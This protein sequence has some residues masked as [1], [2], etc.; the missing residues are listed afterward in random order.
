MFAPQIVI[1]SASAQ[2]RAGERIG[3]R[4]ISLDHANVFRSIDKDAVPGEQLVDL[5][6]LRDEFIQK[7]IETRNKSFRQITNLS[8]DAGVGRSKAGTSEKFE[9]IVKLFALGK[10]VKENGHRAEVESHGANPE[11][12]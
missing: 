3:D 6:Q 11:E 7:F 8:A 12:V 5:V 9:E 2:I 10:G 1:D 4:T